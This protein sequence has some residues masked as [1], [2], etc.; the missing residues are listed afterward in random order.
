MGAGHAG[1]VAAEDD[2]AEAQAHQV[3][4]DCVVA[5]EAPWPSYTYP[6]A[7]GGVNEKSGNEPLSP[8]MPPSL[9]ANRATGAMASGL[10]VVDEAAAVPDRFAHAD[11]AA[12]RN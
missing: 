3:A 7:V 12:I 1:V 6:D 4:V 5:R 9:A 10:D 2:A 11:E 8:E